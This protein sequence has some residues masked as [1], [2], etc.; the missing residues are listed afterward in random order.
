MPQSLSN[1]LIHLIFST[2]N[3]ASLIQPTIE[4][5]LWRYLA[6]TCTA[7]GCDTIQVGGTQDHIHIVCGL[8]RT[9][10][11][12]E[13]LEEIKK[14][15]SKWMKT[16]GLPSFGWQNG[17]GAFSVGQ[18]Q[19]KG[20]VAYINGQKKHHQGRTFQDEYREFLEKYHIKYDERY[21]WD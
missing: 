2:K 6:T 19:L 8:S 20:L 3:R 14:R 18:S 12:S 17:Y 21:V 15:S 11:I 16:K 10:A 1:I 5:E 9:V 7:C 13:L 4:D